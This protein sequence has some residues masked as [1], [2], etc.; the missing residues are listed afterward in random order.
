MD[1]LQCDVQ[2]IYPTMFIHTVTSEPDVEVAVHGA[3]NRWLAARTAPTNGRLRWAYLPPILSMDRAVRDMEWAKENGACAVMKKGVEYNRAA[4][5]PYFYPLYAEA[6]R[7]N[8]PICFHTGDGDGVSNTTPHASM[9]H[10][11]VLHAF[12]TL[13]EDRTPERFPNLRFGF[14]EAGADWIPYQLKQIGMRGRSAKYDCKFATELL[15]YYRFYVTCD[16]EDDVPR[17]VTECGVADNLMIGTDYSHAD[18]SAEL[19]AHEVLRDRE[20]LSG[21]V[22]DKIASGNASRL[23][24][25]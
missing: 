19:N 25:L 12:R 8:L 21:E 23:Y 14:I 4:S 11:N 20:D 9:Q 5:D 16:T 22:V 10:F 3:Y 1:E 6:E 2:V 15:T 7:L 18:L 13:A 24:A 17:L